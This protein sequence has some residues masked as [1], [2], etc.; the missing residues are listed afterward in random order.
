MASA[1]EDL[2]SYLE[3]N[4]TTVKLYEHRE[5]RTS[6]E[7]AQARAEAGA[8][9]VTGAKAILIKIDV[10]GGGPQF[11][12]LVLPGFSRVDSKRL[13][14]ELKDRVSGFRSF[15]FATSDEMA[16]VARGMQPGCMPPFGKPIFP[17]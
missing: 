5:C 4:S 3:A 1:N 7:S 17:G 8:G 6:E 13:R 10:R 11:F 15:R 14:T 12:L 2:L 9:M 16:Q